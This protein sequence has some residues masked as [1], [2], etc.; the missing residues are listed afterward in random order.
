MFTVTKED[1][2]RILNDFGIFSDV[3]TFSELQRYDYEI[4]NPSSKEVRLIIKVD[5]NNG[6]SV[7][8]RFKNESDATLKVINEQSRFA[9]F[10]ADNGIKTPA[11]FM[12]N[13]EYARWY[14][15]NRYDVIVT[16]EE[17]VPG[18]IRLVSEKI[19]EKTGKL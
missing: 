5:L 14:T 7:V 17:F 4:N 12:T 15:I 9:K 8:V 13:Y 19:A 6:Q 18:E 1:I 3:I 16:V 10:L 11:L 2:S